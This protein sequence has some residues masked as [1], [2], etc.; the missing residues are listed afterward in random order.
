MTVCII[1]LFSTVGSRENA[2]CYV[3]LSVEIATK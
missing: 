2:M 3:V 1:M